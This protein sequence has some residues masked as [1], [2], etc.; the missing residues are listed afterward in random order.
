MSHGNYL[1]KADVPAIVEAEPFRLSDMARMILWLMIIAGAAWF[2]IGI[3]GSDAKE[4][5][6]AFHINFV[7]WFAIAAAMT[8][9]SAVFHICNAEWVRPIRRIFE[10]ASTFF[11]W[12]FIPLIVL[13]FGR[14]HLFVWISEPAPAKEVWLSA[15]FVHIRDIA[16]ALVLIFVS[17]KIVYYSLRRDIGAMRSGMTGLDK[18]KLTRWMGSTYD[19]FVTG[20]SA[21]G[22]KELQATQD[23]MGILSPFVILAY[24]LAMSF[25]AFDQI[26]S[27]DPHWYSTMF[28][29]FYFMSAVYGA[30]A[31]T[32]ICLG[33][34][35]ESHPLFRSKVIRP[36]C[37]D[38][39]K[40]LFGFGIFWAYL[41][42]SHYLPMWYGN[43]PEETGWIIT[44]LREEPWHSVA[45]YV[46]GSCFIVPFLLGISR[47]VKQVPALLSFTA[48]IV[49]CGLWVLM[50]LLFAPS[51]FLFPKEVPL[52]A[53]EL[54]ISLGFFGVFALSCASFL[55]KYP[56]MP[57]GD[58]Y[59]DRNPDALH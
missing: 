6:T 55:E 52:S 28:G 25:I 21:D 43:M 38:L 50:Y 54:V 42:W 2:A 24:A 10:S 11:Q 23:R 57:F 31:W 51:P 17:R 35:R 9:F 32:A 56:L 3:A 4:T 27:S 8:S 1:T 29:G 40:L 36:T 18:S 44:R 37:H 39:G 13:Y 45:W 26:M 41:F 34:V 33:F 12:S 46:F 30:V 49:V 58:L 16:A 48:L 47:D 15:P 22:Q 7:Y 59:D 20:W 53:R 14:E 19:K 5:W